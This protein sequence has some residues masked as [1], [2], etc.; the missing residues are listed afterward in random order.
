MLPY[1]ISQLCQYKTTMNVRGV[2][3]YVYVWMRINASIATTATQQATD[4][5]Q[6]HSD[7]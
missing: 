5:K 4:E 2:H 1:L 3:V 6:K 7:T